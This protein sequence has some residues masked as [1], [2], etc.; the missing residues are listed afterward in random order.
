MQ[1]STPLIANTIWRLSGAIGLDNCVTSAFD[2]YAY[3]YTSIFSYRHIETVQLCNRPHHAFANAIW[4]LS[5]VIG[6][7]NCVASVFDTYAYIY[8][9]LIIGI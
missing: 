6:L 9:F 8:I 4:R 7:D 2:T 1:S 3:I 5:T